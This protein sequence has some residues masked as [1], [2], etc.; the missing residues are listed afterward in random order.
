[1]F[2]L[3][4]VKQLV[5]TNW[6]PEKFLK[7]LGDQAETGSYL[8]RQVDPNK[9]ISFMVSHMNCYYDLST[10][11]DAFSRK[12]QM[13]DDELWDSLAYIIPMLCRQVIQLL[14]QEPMI[15]P[16]VKPDALVFGDV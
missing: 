11:K 4:N 5:G 15:L 8:D 10:D 13:M 16:D 7:P 3:Q 1:E 12:R 6:N 2:Q 9:L 14:R